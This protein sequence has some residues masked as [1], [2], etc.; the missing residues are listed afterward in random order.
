[1]KRV[2][3]WTKPRYIFLIL[4]LIVVVGGGVGTYL[5]G[6]FDLGIDFEAGLNLHLQISSPAFTIAYTGE[7]TCNFNIANSEVSIEILRS[8]AEKR[9]YRYPF[10]SYATVGSIINGLSSIDGLVILPALEFEGVLNTTESSR[11]IGLNYLTTLSSEPFYVNVIPANESEM[12]A[13]IESV[14]RA[15]A[16]AGVDQIQLVGDMVNQEFILKIQDDGTDKNFSTNASARVQKAL[17]DY[18]GTGTVIVKQ[19]DYVG[20]R[21][22]QDLAQQTIYLFSFALGLI[23]LYIWFRFKLAF[24]VSAIIALIHDV[25]VMAGFI[26]LSGMEVSTATIAA[27]LT[28]IGYSLNDTIVIFDRIRENNGL[29]RDENLFTIVD[30]SISQSISRTLMTSITT[31]LAVVA[32]YIFGSGVMKDFA[33]ALIVGII[34]GTYSSIFIASPIYLGWTN[35]L[36]KRKKLK[37]AQ[38]YG[39]KIEVPVSAEKGKEPKEVPSG[40]TIEKEP[41][42]KLVPTPPVS[43]KQ[44]RKKRKKK[45]H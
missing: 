14:R 19:T 2:I 16:N 44:K 40:Q 13:P 42:R 23:L 17:A 18:F 28:I 1:M 20:P 39:R 24:A 7:G 36:L 38:K 12:T 10:S 4:S 3:R 22:S 45:K 29:M 8:G 43:R 30:T 11:I 26:G 32:I 35:R 25:A 21:F 33:L 34:V 6:G 9:T 37:D 41:E 15:V 5:K 27:G 31:L